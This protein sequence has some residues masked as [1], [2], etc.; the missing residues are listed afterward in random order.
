[1][2][3]ASWRLPGDGANT[4]EAQQPKLRT[5]PEITVRRLGNRA[6]DT[7]GKA[8][9]DPPRGVR[10]LTNVQRRIQRQHRRTP[11]QQHPNQQQAARE[12]VLSSSVRSHHTA[13]TWSPSL[14]GIP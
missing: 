10:V 7:F 14:V 2:M 3:F 5:Q 12:T 13:Y 6:D 11:R 8:V 9:A 1:E 4:I